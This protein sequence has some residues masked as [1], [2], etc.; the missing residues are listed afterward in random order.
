MAK[1]VPILCGNGE[2]D[3]G[4]DCLKRATKFICDVIALDNW[5]EK[6]GPWVASRH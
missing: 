4:R 6:Y 2:L 3:A 5:E 1:G